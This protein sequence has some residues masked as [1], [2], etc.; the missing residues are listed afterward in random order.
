MFNLTGIIFQDCAQQ[1][2]DSIVPSQYI[3]K[4]ITKSSNLVT[5]NI[6]DTF[7]NFLGSLFDDS[8]LPG[9]MFSENEMISKG[10]TKDKF[11]SIDD[12][13]VGNQFFVKV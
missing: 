11:Q 4:Y 10:F 8:G 7:P 2:C 9:P 12:G 3:S 13:L 5:L 1:V 6:N